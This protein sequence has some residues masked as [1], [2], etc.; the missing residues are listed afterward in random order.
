[1][2]KTL[3]VVLIAMITQLAWSQTKGM[4]FEHGK[5]WAEITAMAKQQNKF[6]FVDC[7]TT[8]CGPCKWMTANVFPDEKTGDF[9]NSK[10]INV[11][12]QMDSTGADNEAVVVMR[13][14]VKR[15]E[16]DF[17]VRAYPTYLFFDPS[18]E[19]VHRAVGSMPADKF[20][21]VGKNALN[22]DKQY[23]S[24]KKKY[25][26][27]NRDGDF[28]FN[29][30]EAAASANESKLVPQFFNAYLETQKD[31]FTKKNIEA[32]AQYTMSS[33]DKGFDVISKNPE[34]ID[35]I[36][37]KDKSFELMHNLAVQEC[38]VPELYNRQRKA[39]DFNVVSANLK[40]KYPEQA[41]EVLQFGKVA[42]AQMKEDWGT[43]QTEVMSYMDKYGSKQSAQNLNQFAWTV[44]ESCDDPSCVAKA[45][46]W[47]LHSLELDAQAAFMDTAA[48]LYHKLGNK[49]KAIEM[50]EKALA[51][52]KADGD[53]ITQYQETLEKMKEDN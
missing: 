48:N 23:V 38:L 7:F 29:L 40:D 19:L 33:K 42:Y 37:G 47:S 53:D 43:F 5:T 26:A 12:L 6:I 25:D 1:M 13:P 3:L 27:G 24:L 36:L 49:E 35:L 50:E 30:T 46:Q 39:P 52:A 9:Y 45:L 34:K 28:L 22:P 41:E 15:F 16:K 51:K 21:E 2:K 20:M 18:G 31:L 8:W 17:Q 44:F 10:F 11:K 32:I 4:Q 14:D